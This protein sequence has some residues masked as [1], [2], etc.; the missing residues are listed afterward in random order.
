[1][2]TVY[3]T[4]VLTTV[5]TAGPDEALYAGEATDFAVV[6]FDQYGNVVDVETGVTFTATVDL[7]SVDPNVEAKNEI[8]F[9]PSTHG[10]S[11]VYYFLNGIFQ[12]TFDVTVNPMAYPFQIT[13]VDTYPAMEEGT[14]TDIM[15]DDVTVIDQYGRTMADPFT[16]DWNFQIMTAAATDLFW[17]GWNGPGNGFYVDA[18]TGD[19][20][21]SATFVAKL[22]DGYM[23]M[24]ESAYTFDIYNVETEDVSGFAMAELPGPMYM[25]TEPEDFEWGQDYTDYFKHVVVTGLYDGME[26]FLLDANDDDLPDLIDLVT[27]TNDA[28]EVMS[29]SILVPSAMVDGTTTV[30]AWKNGEAVA[31]ADLGLSDT[32]PDLA[33]ITQDD[34]DDFAGY[35]VTFNYWDQYGVEWNGHD[36]VT[37]V[38]PDTLL[39]YVSLGYF[40]DLDGTGIS[41]TVIKWDGLVNDTFF[42]ADDT[43]PF[44][45]H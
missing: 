23:V 20:T 36:V 37:G 33:T 32:A 15:S 14:T 8:G 7:F 21:G 19:D 25:G 5:E 29:G 34:V 22:V 1:M 30:K 2:I 26:V 42:D 39:P 13:D 24:T 17:T 31:M 12:G 10:T 9:T 27:S 28:V 41:Y 3:A 18:R 6:G 11:T 45:A 43:V 44:S 38:N 35:S 40:A 4:P 16:G